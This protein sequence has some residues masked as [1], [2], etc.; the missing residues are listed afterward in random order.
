MSWVV[1][2]RS[3]SL[4]WRVISEQR[5]C[6]YWRKNTAWDQGEIFCNEI[7]WLWIKNIRKFVRIVSK[8]FSPAWGSSVSRAGRRVAPSA[9]M[10]SSMV[11]RAV[12]R[13]ARLMA[14]AS[15]HLSIWSGVSSLIAAQRAPRHE[16]SA[17]REVWGEP[18]R[19][20]VKL[21][22]SCPSRIRPGKDRK[23]EKKNT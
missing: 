2:A 15:A 16:D 19:L 20:R 5:D 12:S 3:R 9:E 7:K 23:I 1:V 21:L 8:I 18:A 13:P 6:E 11:A 4:C 14:L 10:I 22:V 17:E